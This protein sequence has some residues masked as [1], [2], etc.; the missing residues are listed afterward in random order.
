VG[1]IATD[2][3]EEVLRNS[4]ANGQAVP[5]YIVRDRAAASLGA[6]VRDLGFEDRF[7][8]VKTEESIREMYSWV[9]PDKAGVRRLICHPRCRHFRGEMLS[10]GR[11]PKTGKIV[12]AFDHGVDA[13]RYGIWDNIAGAPADIDIADYSQGVHLAARREV[14]AEDGTLLSKRQKVDIAVY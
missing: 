11:N 12:K 4:Y 8:T 14:V 7:Y 2:H 5:S 6:A 9:S 3:L 1:K 10:Y 13:V